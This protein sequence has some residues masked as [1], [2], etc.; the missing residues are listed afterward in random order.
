MES[1][2]SAT[3]DIAIIGAGICGLCTSLALSEKGHRVTVYERDIPPPPGG[4]EEAFFEW[5]RR[6]AA[7]FRHPHAFLG[8]MCNILED[9]YPELIEAFWEAGA[10]RVNF[11]EMLP[12]HL[13]ETYEPAPGDES[14]WMLLCRRATMETVLRRYATEKRGVTIINNTSV[15]AVSTDDKL[16]TARVSGLELRNQDGKIETITPDVVIDA[17]GR[18]TKF[19]EWF[20]S[21]GIE[22]EVEDDDAELVY[23]TRHYKL[24]PGETEPPRFGKTRS[25]GDLGYIKYGVFPGDNG[26]FAVILCLPNDETELREAVK[27]DEDFQRMCMAIPGLEPWVSENKSEPTTHSFGFGD[28]HAVWRHFV[29]DGIPQILNYFAVGDAAVRTNPLYGRGC[30]TGILHAHLLAELLDRER[31]PVKRAIAFSEITEEEIRPI[32]KTSL[33]DDKRGIERAR[34]IREG[35]RIE[36]TDTFRKWLRAAFLDAIAAAAR[37]ELHVIRGAMRTFNLMEKPGTFLKDRRTQL[38]ILRYMFKGRRKN[39]EARYQQGPSREEMI[40]L[41]TPTS[42]D[43]AA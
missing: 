38:T 24:L 20:K 15:M 11:R 32:F 7:Q 21:H 26:H 35:E 37:E 36:T 8:V 10:R 27:S 39:A 40:S 23:Y 19:P 28:I 17:S 5:K 25:A 34:A 16:G 2:H 31:D 3:Q 13:M 14:L 6:G 43:V 9:K 1:Q 42:T 4:A 22:F 41:I 30:S 18:T 33:S 12:P 29:K